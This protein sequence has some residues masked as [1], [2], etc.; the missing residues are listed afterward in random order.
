MD[1]GRNVCLI[2]PEAI[3]VGDSVEER[4]KWRE[5]FAPEYVITSHQWDLQS[6]RNSRLTS[7]RSCH[8]FYAK[9]CIDILDGKTKWSGMDED[10]ELM[11]DYGNRK[12][13]KS[14]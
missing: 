12:S 14:E 11:D 13:D 7:F 3:V 2:F 4:Q 8:I 5:A 10:S 6:D 9:R 1:E